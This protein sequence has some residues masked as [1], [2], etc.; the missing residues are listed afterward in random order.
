MKTWG[1]EPASFSALPGTTFKHLVNKGSQAVRMNAFM[2]FV[3]P[4]SAVW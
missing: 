1:P 4:K 2:K 3:V